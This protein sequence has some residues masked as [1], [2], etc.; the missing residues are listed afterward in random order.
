[1][2]YA[3]KRKIY[4]NFRLGLNKQKKITIGIWNTITEKYCYSIKIR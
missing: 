4:C 3:Q 2:Y 1:M